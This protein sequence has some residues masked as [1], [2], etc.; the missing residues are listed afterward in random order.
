MTALKLGLSLSCFVSRHRQNLFPW[1]RTF[2]SLLIRLNTACPWQRTMS[3]L[4]LNLTMVLWQCCRPLQFWCLFPMESDPCTIYIHR[5]LARRLFLAQL[6][7]LPIPIAS[8]LPLMDH[9]TLICSIVNSE[10]NFIMMI[11]PT[12]VQFCHLNS[13]HAFD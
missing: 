5:I 3:H 9:P 8:V 10:L 12:S 1:P 2:G 13:R 11:T 7:Y 6:S 4:W